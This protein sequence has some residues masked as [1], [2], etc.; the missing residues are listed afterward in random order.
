MSETNERYVFSK[1]TLYRKTSTCIVFIIIMAHRQNI[2]SLFM[3]MYLNVAAISNSGI[4]GWG[5]VFIFVP[6]SPKW[7]VG[8]GSVHC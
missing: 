8:A 2:V 5:N 7:E 4:G 6:I 3:F 1:N